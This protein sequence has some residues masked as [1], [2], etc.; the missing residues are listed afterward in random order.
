MIDMNKVFRPE[1]INEQ[2]Q[3]A[4]DFFDRSFIPIYEKGSYILT[5]VEKAS[6]KFQFN[7]H[8][9][10]Y[11]HELLEEWR[12]PKSEIVKKET[13]SN[14][15]YKNIPNGKY[16]KTDGT[17]GDVVWLR[18]P[19]F[20]DVEIIATAIA[21][22]DIYK[23]RKPKDKKVVLIKKGSVVRVSK[24]NG[25]IVNISVRQSDGSEYQ[26]SINKAFLTEIKIQ[27]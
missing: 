13:P 8:E 12:S 10:L 7:F 2:V 3:V 25:D 11:F 15:K 9:G 22:E 6:E 1:F 16:L 14:D 5:C 17:Y 23:S 20:S 24:I 26:Q 18:E 4:I 19:G 21:N 27:K